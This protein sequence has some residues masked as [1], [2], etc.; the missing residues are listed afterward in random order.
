M[1]TYVYILLVYEMSHCA[2]ESY[3]DIRIHNEG[4]LCENTRAMFV[5]DGSTW[6]LR[7][8]RS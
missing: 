7:A 8:R 2:M 5:L 3:W 6:L 4:I 1:D